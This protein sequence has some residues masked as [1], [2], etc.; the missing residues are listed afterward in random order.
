[1]TIYADQAGSSINFAGVGAGDIEIY[2]SAAI[3]WSSNVFHEISVEWTESVCEIYLDGALAATGDG[4]MY[5]R[6]GAP[7]AMGFTLAR[8]MPA[9]NRPGGRMEYDHLG[10]R[11]WG[12]VHEWLD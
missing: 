6:R 12:M 4:V 11:V 10:S 1:M 9:T 7:G 5:V 8:I 2:A 3:S